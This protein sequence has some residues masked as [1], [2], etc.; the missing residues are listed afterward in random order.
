[1]IKVCTFSKYYDDI[2]DFLQENNIDY[3]SE[4]C[5]IRC[6]LCHTHPFVKIDKSFI[7]DENIN[8]FYKK[9]L[10]SLK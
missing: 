2:I 8:I 3:T 5:L 9:L 6:D 1:M 7:S 4:E 10:Q